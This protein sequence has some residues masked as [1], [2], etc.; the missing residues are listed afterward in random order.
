MSSARIR[1]LTSG[2][3]LILFSILFYH[4][5][6]RLISELYYL[7][8]KENLRLDLYGLAS[9][10]LTKALEFQNTDYRVWNHL[11]RAYHRLGKLKP[12]REAFRVA[13]KSEEA[14]EEAARLNP[15]DAEAAFG[16]AREEAR[17]RGLSAYLQPN[18][19]PNPYEASPYFQRAIQLRPNGVGYYYAYTRYLYE[20]GE[21][22]GLLGVIVNLSRIYPPVYG[23]LKKEPFWSSAAERAVKQGLEKAI[24]E[25]MN[26]REAH[27]ALSTLMAE[28]K[29]FAGAIFHYREALND[30]RAVESSGD[31]LHLGGLYLESGQLDEAEDSFF[32]ALSIS[33]NI[34][35]SLNRIHGAYRNTNHPEAMY[36]L[37]QRARTD[38]P[39][40]PRMNIVIARALIDSGSYH[41]AE[42]I[43][44]QLNRKEPDAEA[45]YWLYRI[46]E[47]EQ[48]LDKMERFI[49]KATIAASTN[50]QYHLLFSSLLGRLKKLDRAEREAGFAIEH[51]D[52]PSAGL[53]GHR[54][55]IRWTKKDYQGA[56]DDWK[57]AMALQPRSASL[58]ARI[59]EAYINLGDQ[60]K[61]TEYYQRAAQ[62]EPGNKRY[63]EKY[64]A[65][66]A[67][68]EP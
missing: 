32:K 36:H 25:D 4:L 17:L 12:A 9:A 2:L 29:D 24:E 64:D 20:R 46:A 55:S 58:C 16:L 38:L 40:S 31:Y 53:F 66:A 23:Q 52:R 11:G 15:L 62:R 60:S 43:L 50:S 27:L 56:I 59:A 8:G 48:D 44:N 7:K 34:E 5:G 30:P 61:A 65:L 37:L 51:A 63:R 21:A 26:S 33:D 35:G 19:N 42:Q 49:Q 6:L 68:A 28:D 22:E 57:A 54:A 3:L 47:K 39:S 14:Y 18:A 45:C 67:F 41:E 10:N 1:Y 13:Q